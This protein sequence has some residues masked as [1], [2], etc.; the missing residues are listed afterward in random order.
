MLSASEPD[1]SG[2]HTRD[3]LE[4]SHVRL[5]KTQRPNTGAFTN[6]YAWQNDTSSAD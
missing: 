5:D 6:R 4:R 1:Y 2:R 3:H